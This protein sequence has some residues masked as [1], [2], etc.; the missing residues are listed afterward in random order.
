M[1]EWVIIGED[2]GK[3]LATFLTERIG[4]RASAKSIKRVLDSNGCQINGKAE[5]FASVSLKKKDHV[6]FDDKMLS[7]VPEVPKVDTS[8]VLFEDDDILAYNKPPGV[9]CD[10]KGILRLLHA[11]HPSLQLI[12][13]LDKETSGVL[14][15]AKNQPALDRMIEEFKQFRVHKVYWAIVDGV[16]EEKKGIVKNY[17]GRKAFFQGQTIWGAVSNRKGMF[18]HTNW[19]RLKQGK[20]CALVACMPITGR[21]HQIRVHLSELGHPILGDHQYGKQFFCRFKA[22]RYLLHAY[23]IAFQHAGKELV[24]KAP[25]P[26]D[27]KKAAKELGLA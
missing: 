7:A 8:R 10:P 23:Q 2:V 15:L 5:R 12:H 19:E 20:E 1:L 3:K 16:L 24:I 22:P 26:D 4:D 27:F 18:A 11:Y 25:I 6:C 9:S 13:R 21:M 14:L 17:L